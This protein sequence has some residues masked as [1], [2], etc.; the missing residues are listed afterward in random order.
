LENIGA[1]KFDFVENKEKSVVEVQNTEGAIKGFFI[2]RLLRV[3]WFGAP[4]FAAQVL[5]CLLYH[6]GKC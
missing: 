1:I 5:S 4:T 2:L 6:Q 3:Y